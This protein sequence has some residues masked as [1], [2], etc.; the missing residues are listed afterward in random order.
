M[1]GRRLLN[2]DLISLDPEIE[3]TFRRRHRP[4]VVRNLLRWEI[5]C[6]RE[7][8]RGIGEKM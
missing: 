3:R 7:R 5:I 6:M 4:P 1:L 2:L 8:M